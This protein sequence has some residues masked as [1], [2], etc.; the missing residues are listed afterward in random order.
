VFTGAELNEIRLKDPA[1]QEK[2]ILWAQTPAEAE[3]CLTPAVVASLLAWKGVP[4]LIKR[5]HTG[6]R[7]ELAGERLKDPADLLA[8]IR[9]GEALLDAAT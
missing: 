6:L 1:L 4:L 9:I 2:Y 7:I 8:F 5:D 3:A